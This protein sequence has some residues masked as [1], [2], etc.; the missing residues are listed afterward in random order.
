MPTSLALKRMNM[1]SLNIMI[2]G[3]IQSISA[4]G[5][6]LCL[7]LTLPHWVQAQA[8]VILS[9]P[10]NGSLTWS[11][12]VVPS[13]VNRIEWASD[14][15]AERW[16]DL[17]HGV[18]PIMPTGTVMTAEVP[19]F[20]RVRALGVP[21]TNMVY[22]PGGTFYMG[23]ISGGA[24]PDALPVH[25][26]FVSPFYM[27]RFEVTSDLYG[28]VHTWSL[29]E[30]YSFS[31]SYNSDGSGYP[32]LE[33]VWYDAVKWCNARSEREGLTPVYYTDVAHTQIYKTGNL[34]LSNAHVKWDAD[35]Y[36]LPTEAEWEK[37]ARGGA[38]GFRFP[39][40]DDTIRHGRATYD[41]F[42][43]LLPYDINPTLGSHPAGGPNFGTTPVGYHSPN[44]YG[45]YDVAGNIVEWCWD[46]YGEN[47]YT[48]ALRM[49]PR[50]PDAGP[51]RVL[52]GGG[53][54]YLASSSQVA[55]RLFLPP[56]DI[57]GNAVIGFRCVRRVAD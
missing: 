37:A 3:A 12:P 14:L 19:M 42:S 57:L 5:I 13:V 9:F 38:Y 51:Y 27:D 48:E 29:G 17:Q 25:P 4:H 11:N 16:T 40:A 6:A 39:W 1:R 32:V 54:W 34:D 10:Q 20:Y 55:M 47:T 43:W 53:A 22:I 35:G 46:R 31:G 44:G 8:P 56:D 33:I 2:S 23:D 50:G 24:E 15:A 41:S 36:R 30:G 21:P 49:N 7:V 28:E 26:V 18:H 52:R 45:L